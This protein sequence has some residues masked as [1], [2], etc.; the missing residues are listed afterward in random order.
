MDNARAHWQDTRSEKNSEHEKELA[1]VWNWGVATSTT[2]TPATVASYFKSKPNPV[3]LLVD[4]S[5][6]SDLESCFY[7][8]RFVPEVL[9]PLFKA[10]HKEAKRFIFSMIL[11]MEERNVFNL[12]PISHVIADIIACVSF[13]RETVALGD[14]KQCH[15]SEEWDK[16][17]KLREEFWRET[18]AAA[19]TSPLVRYFHY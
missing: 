13:T 11:R 10:L 14:E 15:F 2:N 18:L 3:S 5:L 4:Y 12:R 19:G 17:S 7:A 1:R 8:H 16:I 6:Y 9:S